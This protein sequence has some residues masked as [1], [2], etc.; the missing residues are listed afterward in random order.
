[1]TENLDWLYYLLPWEFSVL[2]TVSTLLAIGLYLRGHAVLKQQGIAIAGWKKPV[3]LLGV[4]LM[5]VVSHT[6]YEYFAQFMFFTHRAQHL[7]LHHMGPFLIA[8]AAPVPV[9]LAGLPRYVQEDPSWQTLGKLGR[10]VYRFLQNPVVAPFLFV[11]LVYFWLYPT[12][13]YYAM[14]SAPLY[15]IMNWSMAIDGLLYWFL[16]FDRRTPA[17]GG[18]AYRWRIAGL[19]AVAPPQIILGAY[20]TFSRLELFDVYAVCGRAWDLDPMVDQ[21][22]GGLITWI[23]PAMMSMLGVMV[24]MRLMFD[25]ERSRKNGSTAEK[26]HDSA[27]PVSA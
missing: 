23:P 9:L 11:G 13:H 5:Y 20:I 3:Y 8:L 24:V 2:W 6:Y 22:I 12:I 17:E 14:L 18:L 16:V 21:Q 7:V 27:H 4:M 10:P 1:M 26:A 15:H 25:H 19:V